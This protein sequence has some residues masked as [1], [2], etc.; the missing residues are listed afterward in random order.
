MIGKTDTLYCFGD[1][2]DP[3]P[4]V[5]GPLRISPPRGEKLQSRFFGDAEGSVFTAMQIFGI[6]HVRIIISITY[7]VIMYIM[8]IKFLLYDLILLRKGAL[9]A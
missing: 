7:V 2:R 5:R 4:D 6:K 1:A 8:G 9:C 3:E